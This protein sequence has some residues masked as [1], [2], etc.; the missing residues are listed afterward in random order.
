MKRTIFKN[1]VIDKFYKGSIDKEGVI[2]Y[3]ERGCCC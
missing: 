1:E 2:G 3:A